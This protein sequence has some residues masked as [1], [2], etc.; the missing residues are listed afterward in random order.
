[1]LLTMH[2][3]HPQGSQESGCDCNKRSEYTGYAAGQLI[4]AQ[5]SVAGEQAQSV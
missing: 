2:L 5:V 4:L 3:M 1:M